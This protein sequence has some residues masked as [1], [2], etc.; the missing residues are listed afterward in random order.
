MLPAGDKWAC[1]LP[2]ARLLISFFH[3]NRYELLRPT[4]WLMADLRSVGT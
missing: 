2:Q 4:P 1:E 3:G